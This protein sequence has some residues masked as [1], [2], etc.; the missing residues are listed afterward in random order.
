M[1]ELKV[2]LEDLYKGKVSKLALQKTILCTGCEGLGGKAGSVKTCRACNGKGSKI[3]MR[4]LGPMI[5]QF[6]SAC[7]DCR[8]Q[9]QIMDEKDKCK[10]C[11]GRKVANERKILEVFVEKGASNGQ[12]ITF[13]GEADQAPGIIP[14]DI[15]IIIDEKPHAR[16][17]RKGVDLYLDVKIDLLTA[18][19]GGQFVVPHLDGRILLVSIIPGE[20]IKPGETKSIANEGMPE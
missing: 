17:K 10:V 8:G 1:H 16:F 11:M 7:G 4:Q 13:T 12:K 3:S 6:Q 20:N 5:Q 2:S 15:V 9:G 19:A 14:G 18:L